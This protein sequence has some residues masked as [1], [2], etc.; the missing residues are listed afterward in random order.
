MDDAD[1]AAKNGKIFHSSKPEGLPV[2]RFSLTDLGP[3]SQW[4]EDVIRMVVWMQ[5]QPPGRLY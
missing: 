3:Q 5:N 1:K 4:T 2:K